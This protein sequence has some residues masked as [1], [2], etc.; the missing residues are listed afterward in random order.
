MRMAYGIWQI[1]ELEGQWGP[2]VSRRIYVAEE[3]TGCP[4]A[5]IGGLS[6]PKMLAT[7]ELGT[8]LQQAPVTLK[9]SRN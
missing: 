5:Q 2:D 4:H 9:A 7:S 3:D 1:A 8:M 6:G